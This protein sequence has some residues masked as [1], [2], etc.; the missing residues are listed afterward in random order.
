MGGG[1]NRPWWAWPSTYTGGQWHSS[2]Q[3]PNLETPLECHSRHVTRDCTTLSVRKANCSLC[4]CRGIGHEA[5][6]GHTTSQKWLTVLVI[7]GGGTRKRP[8]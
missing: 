4:K 1:D 2:Q 3:A 7:L 6:P 5:R 8:L